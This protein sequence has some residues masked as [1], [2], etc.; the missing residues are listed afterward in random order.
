[1]KSQWSPKNLSRRMFVKSWSG[2]QNVNQVR[3]AFGVISVKYDRSK[4]FLSA[5]LLSGRDISSDIFI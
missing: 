4:T 5:K 2:G 3:M 1:M